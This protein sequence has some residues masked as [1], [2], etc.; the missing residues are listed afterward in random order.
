MKISKLH[1]LVP[2]ICPTL[3]ILSTLAKASSKI[4]TELFPQCPTPHK[5]PRSDARLSR[6]T[7]IPSAPISK[8]LA[9]LTLALAIISVSVL[10]VQNYGKVSINCS[11]ILQ[12]SD[13]TH[14]FPVFPA[15]VLKLRIKKIC[16]RNDMQMKSRWR[17]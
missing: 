5:L 3:N 1:C 17:M 6:N 7:A 14:F 12:F 16:I 4:E 9:T 11:Q 13:L 15:F 10:E 2:S 8:P